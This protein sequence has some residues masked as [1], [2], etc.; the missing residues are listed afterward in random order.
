MNDSAEQ[1]HSKSEPS[2]LSIAVNI[3]TSPAEA[4]TAL[5]TSP[6]KLFPLLLVIVLN[7][8]VLVWYF[9]IVDFDWYVDDALSLAN[10]EADQLDEAREG[11]TS[12]SPNT[13]MMF[14]V[15]GSVVGI[16]LI[17][18][19]QAGY[20]SL[21]SAL[22]GENYKF[23]HWLSMVSWTGLPIIL[24]IIGM[25]VTILLTPNGQLSSFDLDPLTLRNLGMQ[26]ENSSVESL[27]ASVNL[28]MIWSIVLMILGH[29]Q[30]LDS[31]WLR[32]IITVSAPYLVILSIWSFFALT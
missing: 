12:M 19:I 14:G 11:M 32:S 22:K 25:V 5:K 6:T 1:S 23:S 27:F 15:L 20:L 26:S 21:V 30:W 4:F 28:P 8:A 2:P 10:I 31:S 13:F 24:S 18:T 29:H 9:N 3:F 16:L 7:T 17:Y